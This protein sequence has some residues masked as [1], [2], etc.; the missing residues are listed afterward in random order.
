MLTHILLYST[1]IYPTLG[2][3]SVLLGITF[4]INLVLWG[5]TWYYWYYSSHT[6]SWYFL[7]EVCAYNWKN[8][9]PNCAKWKT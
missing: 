3:T 5:I 8:Y 9:F 7:V 2:L 1:K 4:G 6:V